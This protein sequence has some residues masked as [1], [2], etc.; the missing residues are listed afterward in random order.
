MSL[1]LEK[2]AGEVGTKHITAGRCHNNEFW[3]TNISL[4]RLR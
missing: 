1:A 4:T 2:V 3:N